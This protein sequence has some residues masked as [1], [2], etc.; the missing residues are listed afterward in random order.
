MDPDGD[1]LDT[2]SRV[3]GL[4]EKALVNVYKDSLY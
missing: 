4:T 2:R 3:T 1:F